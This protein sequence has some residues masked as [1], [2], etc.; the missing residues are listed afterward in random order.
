V[1]SI[2]PNA[3][4]WRPAPDTLAF[5][6]YFALAALFYAPILAGLRVFPAGDFTEFF[7]PFSIFQRGEWLAGRL[8]LWNPFTYAGHPFLAD[9]QAAVFY[10]VS[11]LLLAL[12]LPWDSP[13]ARLYWLQVEA[14]LHV[15]LAGCFT[16]VLARDL[17][18][19]RRAAF[20]AGGVFAF[21]GYLTGYPPL[22]L[23]VLRTAIW[24][25][26]ILWLLR[27]A[28]R[29][30]ARWR[31]WVEAALAYA[32]AFFAGHP[33][34]FLFLS[35]A[36][37][38]WIVALAIP[39]IRGLRNH[40]AANMAAQPERSSR[41]VAAAP[42][43]LA[44][45]AVFYLLFLGLSAAQLWPSIEFTTL[46]VR[47]RV[48]YAFVSGGF[49]LR[50]TWQMLLP[51]I[52]SLFSP[53]YVGL[54]AL[55]LA[56]VGSLAA[57]RG[58]WDFQRRAG[59][60]FTL[61]A[62]LALG[63]SYGNHGFLYPVF[64]RWAPGWALFRGQERAAYL[65]AFGLSMLAGY[66]A[67]ALATFSAR[68]RRSAGLIW[69]GIA[70]A[71]LIAAGLSL[72]PAGG[73]LPLRSLAF[74]AL[75]L[76]AWGALLWGQ[77]AGPRR[78]VLLIALVLV[79]LWAVNIT[80]NLV[81]NGE[82]RQPIP[83]P[84]AARLLAAVSAGGPAAGGLSGR[85][86][87]DGVLPDNTGMMIGVEEL[88]GSSP[89][90]LARYAALLTDFPRDRLWRLTGV[91]HVLS[92]QPDLYAPSERL[93]ELPGAAGPAF[94]YRL[95][96]PQPRAWVV[97]TV[98]VA[99]DA[100]ALP[101]LGDAGFDPEQTALLPPHPP[102]GLEEGMLALPGANRVALERRA[103]NRLRAHVESAHGG[104]LIVSENWLPGWRATAQRTGEAAARAVPV[105]RA[106]LTL[107]AIPVRPGESV[108]ELV[109]W[110]DSVR[111][112]LMISGATLFLVGLAAVIRKRVGN[113]ATVAN[114]A[115]I[116]AA[117]VIL[118]AAALWRQEAGGEP[119]AIATLRARY[120]AGWPAGLAVWLT[121]PADDD[122]LNRPPGAQIGPDTQRVVLALP[123][124][125]IPAAEA[126]LSE[127]VPGYALVA[128]APA[129][130]W[131]VR[132]Y[133]RPPA[134]LPAVDVP[135]AAGWRLTGADVPATVWVGGDV[136]PITLQWAGQAAALRGQEKLTLQLLD[137][138][139]RLVAQTDQ[140]F[141]AAELAAPLTRYRLALPRFLDPGAYR[142]IAALYDPA[143]PGAPRLPTAA[144]ADHVE[145]AS[146]PAR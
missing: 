44:R 118:L 127:I 84:E 133:D 48:D 33:Q 9:V 34:T 21:S 52:V 89:L 15:A 105:L 73:D 145:L 74:G 83:A 41:V 125:E 140:P 144:G 111:F 103:P 120:T 42:K 14:V 102:A 46:S 25:P 4:N 64:Y 22:Q 99:E 23:A 43:D 2:R 10:P 130:D 146:R 62:L 68:Q 123:A 28:F 93:A 135:F 13:A 91:S 11:N 31:G 124:A 106:D 95:T 5:L 12:T 53:L 27:R 109:Y 96:T 32:V 50:D 26:L 87:N 112:G 100:Q 110:P 36:V 7:L 108:I 115:L 82:N 132:V 1:T 63:V 47:A 29:A 126:R 97:H 18:H 141:G 24:L 134:R 80:T 86:F 81:P 129:G 114:S 92:R 76:L 79:D 75:L 38:G 113:R 69:A 77:F 37:A 119:P 85:V 71:G 143:R 57:L 65:V 107:L 131:R 122:N 16:Y 19:D 54:A 49:P 78:A 116:L 61:L 72:R 138:Q 35:Y 17:L 39:V 8:P 128:E 139:G 51:G 94:L 101:L 136:V 88:T 121:W 6:A 58:P 59:L 117:A 98:R 90:R 60:Y 30:P 137:A 55:G 142:L 104:L 45:V 56:I 3:A 20:L 67:A 70:G 40:R 66:G